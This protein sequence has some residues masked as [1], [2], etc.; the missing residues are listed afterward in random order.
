[1][2][3]L[4][5]LFSCSSGPPA[6]VQAADPPTQSPPVGSVSSVVEAPPEMPVQWPARVVAIGDLHA[7]LPTTLGVLRL[8]GLVDEEG[9]WSGGDTVFVQTGDQTD[10]GPD[11]KEV[12][13]LLMALQGQAAAAG[14]QVLVLL[15][16][17]EVMNLGGDLRY[18]SPLD[19]QDFGS[20]E[21][22][23][24]AFSAD[25]RLGVWLRERPMVAQVGDTVFVHGGITPRFAEMGISGMNALASGVVSGRL[26]AAQLGDDSPIWYRGY[27]QGAG[28]CQE[29]ERA[30][31]SLGAQRMVVGHT[32]QR[33]G[34]IA[35]GC[36]GRVLGID[37]GISSHYGAHAAAVEFRGGDAWVLYPDGTEDV[38]D[39]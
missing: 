30:L 31:E 14:G 39:P 9:Q 32:T 35:V 22:R 34:R 38:P 26:P 23:A 12:L 8:A 6:P 5:L 17:H 2:L 25:G 29:L 1:L 3:N 21:Q 7:D 37:T 15:G 28:A 24:Q 18:V 4:V 33:T 13:E 11:S 20:P 36:E 10:R 19:V 27:L 16:N